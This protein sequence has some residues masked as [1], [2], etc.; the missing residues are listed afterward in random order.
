[1]LVDGWRASTGRDKATLTVPLVAGT[2]ASTTPVVTVEPPQCVAGVACVVGDAGGGRWGDLRAG[3]GFDVELG[4]TLTVTATLAAAGVA[5]A[6]PLDWWL[7][8]RVAD[9]GDVH[10]HLGDVG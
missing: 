2:C 4:A 7:G 1:M 5:W 10:G 3:S 8:D 9:G 6:S